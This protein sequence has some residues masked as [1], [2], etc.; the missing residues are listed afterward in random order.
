M[1]RIDTLIIHCSYTPP[2]MDIGA[3]EIRGWHVDDNKWSDIGYHYVIRR[4]GACQPGRPVQRVGA[5]A[6]DH[7][8][9][10]IG[11][12]LVGGMAEHDKR[13]DCNFTAS[14]WSSLRFL[15]REMKQ[16][17]DIER[18]IGHRDVDPGRACPTFDV[19]AWAA[20]IPES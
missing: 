7:N 5:H 8:S 12:C 20:S 4:D 9:G 14:Q 2:S 17:Y 13:P 15:V 11:I 18:V 19:V 10:S 6:K 3:A 1:R 16:L